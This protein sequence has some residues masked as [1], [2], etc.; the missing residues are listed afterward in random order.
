M[1]YLKELAFIKRVYLMESLSN[2][3]KGEICG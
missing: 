2:K 1:L 3:T